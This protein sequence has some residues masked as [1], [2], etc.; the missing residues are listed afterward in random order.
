MLLVSGTFSDIQVTQPT[1]GMN[2]KIPRGAFESV[3][4]YF[5]QTSKQ[6]KTQ[7]QE[8]ESTLIYSKGFIFVIIIQGLLNGFMNFIE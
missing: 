3:L 5:Q 8:T 7:K 2:F 1:V 6:N 4:S